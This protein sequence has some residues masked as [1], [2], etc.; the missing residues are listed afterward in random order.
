M[1]HLR[2]CL[3]GGL[4]LGF[5][6]AL[7]LPV[8]AVN[9]APHRAVYTLSLGSSKQDSGIV[10]VDGTMS[11]QWGET[12]DGWTVEQR[13]KMA[14]H[15]AEDAQVELTSSFVTVES[16]DGLHYRYWERK[17][18]DGE[19]DEEV[20]GE[21]SLA[22]KDQ[23][24]AASFTKP[25]ESSIKLAPGVLF[26]TAHTILLIERAMAGDHFFGKRLFDGASEDNAVDVTAVIGAPETAEQGAGEATVKSPLLARPSWRI[27]L[28]FFPPDASEEADKPDY[29]IGMRLLDN[30][31]SRDMLL[32]YGDFAIKADLTEIEA[33]PKPSC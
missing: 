21:A 8:G 25:K 5:S 2:F 32:D 24:G 20:R 23:G 28:A 10:G 4:A 19:P 14:M 22:G 27:R 6:S 16:K 7:A 18:K 33:L 9:V 11:F 30:G 1:T 17:T 12:C 26:P 31:I 29:E 3:M 13:Y 15:Y